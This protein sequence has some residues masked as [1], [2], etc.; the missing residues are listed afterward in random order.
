MINPFLRMSHIV[1]YIFCALSVSKGT[2][3]RQAQ[4]AF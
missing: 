3:L 2:V 4:H 1:E